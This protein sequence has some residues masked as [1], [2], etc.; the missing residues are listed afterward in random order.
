MVYA[1]LLPLTLCIASSRQKLFN[2]VEVLRADAWKKKIEFGIV[3]LSS[4]SAAHSAESNLNDGCD[5]KMNA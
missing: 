1:V 3:I 5:W 4:T 2:Y